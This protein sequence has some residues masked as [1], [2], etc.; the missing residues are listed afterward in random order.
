MQRAD[1]ISELTKRQD[2]IKAFGVNALFL[3]GSYARDEGRPDSDIDVFIDRQDG[4]KFGFLEL[5]NLE[6]FLSDLFKKN[7]DVVT[8]TALHPDLRSSIEASAIRVF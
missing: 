1:L 7:V 8:R 3:F 5:T 4:H 2:A 6:F